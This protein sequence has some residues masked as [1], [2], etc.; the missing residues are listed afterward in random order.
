MATDRSL[1]SRWPQ[2]VVVPL[3]PAVAIGGFLIG[4]VT[5]GDPDTADEPGATRVGVVGA[6][7]EDGTV[8][9]EETRDCY[10]VPGAK[11]RVGMKIR[12]RVAKQ[13]IDP[14]DPAAGKRPVLVWVK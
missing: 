10:L 13:L 2:V 7:D 1:S 6:V 12:Y 4:R 8:C 11:V 3:L 9:I 14:D 5:A